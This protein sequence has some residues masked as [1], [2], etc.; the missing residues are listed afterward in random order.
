MA[1][2]KTQF[3]FRRASKLLLMLAAVAGIFLSRHA[4]E[5]FM[6]R[7]DEFKLGGVIDDGTSSGLL[8][9]QG[10]ARKGTKGD[11]AKN[12]NEG[13]GFF[14]FLSKSVPYCVKKES[15]KDPIEV[16]YVFW[17]LTLLGAL[18]YILE[19]FITPTWKKS[20]KEQNRGR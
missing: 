20:V 5:C 14:G 11:Y 19:Q 4:G 6:D 18:F 10:N 8:G 3:D 9:D 13:A 1:H 12:F 15:F 17:A 7:V 2:D 16:Y